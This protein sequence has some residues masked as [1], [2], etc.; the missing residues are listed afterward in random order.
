[1]NLRAV[2]WLLGCVLL[3]LAVFLLAPAAVGFYYGE[4]APALACIVSAVVTALVGGAAVFFNRG[5]IVRASDGRVDYFRREG[6]AVVGLSWLLAGIF[7]AL[8]F[9]FS[10]VL[11]S[12]VDAFFESASGFTTTG[13]TIMSGDVIDGMPRAISFW[14]SFTH[15]LGGIGIVLVFV[16][17]LPTGGR[18]LFRSEVP[19]ISREATQQRVRDSALALLRVYVLLTVVQTL[20]LVL[21]GLSIFDSVV[22]AFGTLA[23]GGF[24]DHSA[25][26]GYYHSWLVEF[27][28]IVFMFL[29]GINFGIYDLALRNGPRKAWRVAVGSTEIR[30]YAGMIVIITL[31]IAVALWLFWGGSNGAPESTLP[32][33]RSFPLALR[34]SLFNVVS[35]QTS[36]GFGTA[37][38]DRWP[39]FCRVLLMFVA[40]TGACAGSTG[41]GLKV[42]RLL[43]VAK[44]AMRG[45]SRFA[46]PRAIHPMLVEGDDLDEGVV[47]S[48]TG[49]FGLWVLVAGAGT[50]LVSAFGIDPV[51]A[52]TSVLAT[53]NNIGPGLNGVGPSMN[54]GQLPDV[55]KVVLTLFMILGRLEFYAVV[56]MFVPGFWRK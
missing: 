36:T 31:V 4:Q 35:L 10:G 20:L 11:S 8:P 21:C 54:F 24:S 50:L 29:A 18:S 7:G 34:D 3:L 12:P 45:I 42:V 23:T 26:V 38:F 2:G 32:D 6:L 19:G 33:Y 25:S 44:A 16:V 30:F 9:L 17:L 1:M 48:V 14:R 37:D 27:V 49:Y 43:I 22:H 13:S 55:V 15:W 53:L 5:S 41:G 28:I 39:Q 40:F 47:A 52:A 56:V 51:T 46:R